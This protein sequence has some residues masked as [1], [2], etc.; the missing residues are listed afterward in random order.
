MKKVIAAVVVAVLLI[1][2]VMAVQASEQKA[3]DVVP[4]FDP[5]GG[6]RT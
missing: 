6:G 5:G 4:Q 1:G 3:A 2:G